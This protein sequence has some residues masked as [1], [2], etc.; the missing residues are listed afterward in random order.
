MSKRS[1]LRRI[2]SATRYSLSGLKLA[3][4]SEPA[5]RLEVWLALLLLPAA[6]WLAASATQLA[7]LLGSVLLVGVVELLNSAIEA[8]VDR[9]GAEFHQLSGRAKDM[10]S[11]AVLLALILCALVWLGVVVDNYWR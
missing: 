8:A 7:L 5:F 1:H 11:A 9:I 4:G 6:F 3:Y 2:R 10:G